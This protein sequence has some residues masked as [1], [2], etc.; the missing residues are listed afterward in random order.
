MYIITSVHVW[1]QMDSAGTLSRG[2]SRRQHD[3][4]NTSREKLE[5]SSKIFLI[6]HYTF[7]TIFAN[8]TML[9]WRH[10]VPQAPLT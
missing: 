2:S 1:G 9:Q 10:R 5:L 6:Y 4:N 7:A 8:F 3:G